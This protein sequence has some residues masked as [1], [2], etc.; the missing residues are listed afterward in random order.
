MMH[1][2]ETRN[3]YAIATERSQL[4]RRS[5]SRSESPKASLT[6]SP[7]SPRSTGRCRSGTGNGSLDHC[8]SASSWTTGS[9]SSLLSVLACS[10]TLLLFTS[11]LGIADAGALM[12]H[13]F[14]K[15]SFMDIQCKG[16]Y[17]K[18]LFARLDRICEDCYNLFRE[19]Q[20]HTL[21]RKNCFTSDYFKGCLDVLLLQDE[22][23][24]IQTSIKQLHGADPG[25]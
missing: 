9:S 13:P 23:E 22:M 6:R 25:V 1:R 21:C 24:W 12:G 14:S 10:M 5:M 18:S 15:R 16:V 7:R 8:S 4:L 2:Q 11:C 20:L 3:S 17:D 19:P